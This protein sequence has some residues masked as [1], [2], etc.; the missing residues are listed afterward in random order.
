MRFMMMVKAD[1][2]YEAGL[3]P[4]PELLQA[5]GKLTDDM[6]KAGVLVQ[7]G[8]L[9][10]SSNGARVR[11]SRGTLS[12]TDGPFPETKELIGG[13]AIVEAT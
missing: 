5:L 11:V 6:V 12:V 2:N 9:L 4:N 13:Y 1:R 7:T 8:G 10:P 3:P